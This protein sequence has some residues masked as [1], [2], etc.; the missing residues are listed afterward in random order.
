M[1]E[2]KTFEMEGD[3]VLLSTRDGTENKKLFIRT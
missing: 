1:N 3:V 2:H